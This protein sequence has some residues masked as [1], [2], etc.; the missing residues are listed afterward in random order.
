MPTLRIDTEDPNV[1]QL[2]NAFESMAQGFV[3]GE[4]ELK[5][6]LNSFD[7]VDPVEGKPRKKM[8]LRSIYVDSKNTRRTRVEFKPS[9]CTRPNCGYDAATANK[10]KSWDHVPPPI[11]PALLD[12]LKN[13]I[14]KIHSIAEETIV[15]EDELPGEWLGRDVTTY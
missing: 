6:P 7:E 9:M 14:E 11:R 3:P 5:E 13:H 1:Q 15:Y 2:A 10:Y 4:D 12:A 8:L